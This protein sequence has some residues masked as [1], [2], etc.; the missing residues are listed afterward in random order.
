MV[1]ELAISDQGGQKAK[2]LTVL[3][4]DAI[5]AEDAGSTQTMLPDDRLPP[6]RF[7]IGKGSE[8]RQETSPYLA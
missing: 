3:D 6:S 2:T 4:R 8:P 7:E 1:L 5:F